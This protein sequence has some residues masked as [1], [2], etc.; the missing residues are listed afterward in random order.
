MELLIGLWVVA[1]FAWW[2][3]S[4]AWPNVTTAIKLIVLILV[5]AIAT[6]SMLAM[7]WDLL[8]VILR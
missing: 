6:T 7:I 4:R 3:T 5:L 1:F 8:Q 2:V